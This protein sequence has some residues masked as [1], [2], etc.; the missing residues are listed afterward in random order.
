MTDDLYDLVIFELDASSVDHDEAR[1]TV[2]ELLG[3]APSEVDDALAFGGRVVSSGLPAEQ[4]QAHFETLRA[5]GVRCNLRPTT[6]SGRS[7]TLEPMSL[8]LEFECPRCKHEHV[9]QRDE[10]PPE[11][12][13]G[14]GLVFAK[15]D[16]V[17]AEIAEREQIRRSLLA[18]KE[19]EAE[20]AER[21]RLEREA[22]ER[23]A[24]IEE[25]LR[26]ELGIPKAV[27]S[28]KGLLAVA[29]GV[30]TLGIGVGVGAS[31]LLRG[32]GDEAPG[33]AVVSTN[34]DDEDASTGDP[35][36]DAHRLVAALD[37]APS[38]DTAT[39]GDMAGLV[40][41]RAT[42]AGNLDA[43]KTDAQYERELA[44]RTD[45]LLARGQSQHAS[46]LLAQATD[47]SRA[48][49]AVT[50]AVVQRATTGGGA[51][52]LAPTFEVLASA[53][54]QMPADS[55]SRVADLAHVV[56]GQISVGLADA[57]APQ[58]ERARQWAAQVSAPAAKVAAQGMVA[59]LLTRLGRR[60]DAMKV[61]AEANAGLSQLK[62][63][64]ERV[65][66][67]V[68]LARS[69][70]DAGSTGAAAMLI[71]DATLSAARIADPTRRTA[72]LR[73]IAL[74]H[75]DAGNPVSARQVTATIDNP[76][77]RAD[78][79]LAL[80]EALLGAG[81]LAAATEV[82][83][84]ISVPAFRA[85][86]L[87]QVAMGQH[88]SNN[89]LFRDQAPLTLQ[90]ARSE[91][92]RIDVPA[93]QAM[94]LAELGRAAHTVGDAASAASFFAEAERAGAGITATEVRHPVLAVLAGNLARADRIGDAQRI[95]AQ[96]ADPAVAVTVT[97]DITR[98]QQVSVVEQQAAA[99]A[100]AMPAAG[101]GEAGSAAATDA[102]APAAGAAPAPAAAAPATA[103]TPPAGARPAR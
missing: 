38:K 56:R 89:A 94:V 103:A 23:R 97:D 78:I 42:P 26:R 68:Q 80:T 85:R 19:R 21:D 5:R 31:M 69:Y 84:L 74:Y 41:P 73:E 75:A 79:E 24:R 61:Y 34:D 59:D 28:R 98:V 37:A 48:I 43:L 102:L 9:Y 95:V 71:E 87:A 51:A 40:P 62:D 44:T 29:A 20:D 17:Q 1:N 12:C 35:G 65:D 4:A 66:A 99:E 6:S 36:L 70:A 76:A 16:K 25:E 46:A 11:I 27:A 81:R 50:N 47:R 15:Y 45:A 82:A 86:A 72:A 101:T 22:A 32:M 10:Q 100:A 63:R 77:V 13:A 18:R 55:P 54:E 2:A 96:I 57:A 92:D 33:A 14:C 7:F 93:T 83:D 52:T 67:V 60:D 49:R 8:E 90:L 58:V 91:A 3:V 53:V 88:G 30:L 64:A 39:P